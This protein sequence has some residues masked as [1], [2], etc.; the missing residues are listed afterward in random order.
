MRIIDI[1]G[2]PFT[3]LSVADVAQRSVFAG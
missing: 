3:P 2:R 1:I